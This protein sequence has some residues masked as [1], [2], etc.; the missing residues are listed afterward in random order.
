[1]VNTHNHFTENGK[2]RGGDFSGRVKADRNI[3][4]RPRVKLYDRGGKQELEMSRYYIHKK[5]LTGYNICI[6]DTINIR[7]QRR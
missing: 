4:Q 6:N 2:Q 7:L 5:R 3:I 1:M